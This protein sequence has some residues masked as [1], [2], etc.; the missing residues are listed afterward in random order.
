MS[1]N[2][3]YSISK[4][5][6]PIDRNSMY[7]DGRYLRYKSK[8]PLDALMEQ[9]QKEAEQAQKLVQAS[10]P[11]Q[12]APEKPKDPPVDPRITELNKLYHLFEIRKKE[13]AKAKRTRWLMCFAGF[14]LVFC[15]AL[16]KGDIKYLF[17]A[18][19]S[20]IIG[21]LIAGIVMTGFHFFVNVS[22]FG[23]LFQKD[24]A[25][26]RRLDE[27]KTRISVIESLLNKGGDTKLN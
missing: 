17:S 13:F 22:I 9:V 21:L 25:A 20:K 4:T 26:D 18:D 16:I 19:M 12:K 23:W 8:D 1:D 10:E 6:E 11:E 24:I 27:L 3:K 5:E 7:E 15:F 14:V 2:K